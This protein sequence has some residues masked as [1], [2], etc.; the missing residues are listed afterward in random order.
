MSNETSA[1]ICSQVYFTITLAY[2]MINI[3]RAQEHSQS[4]LR[5]KVLRGSNSLSSSAK[6]T[7][8][9]DDGELPSN[10]FGMR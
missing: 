4:I 1:W 10:G 9:F 2:S 8:F 7:T 3:A 6:S 5:H